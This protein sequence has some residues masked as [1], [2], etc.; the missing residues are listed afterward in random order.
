MERI[1]LLFEE[2]KGLESISKIYLDSKREIKALA[3]EIESLRRERDSI[4]TR[5][6]DDE[7]SRTENELEMVV[8]EIEC[9]RLLSNVCLSVNDLKRFFDEISDSPT[10]LEKSVEFMRNL[11]V[12]FTLGSQA[13][14]SLFDVTGEEEFYSVLKIDKD[15]EK[16][17]ELIRTRDFYKSALCEFRN[18]MK[19]ELRNTVPFDIQ[20]F[21]SRKHIF[22]VY[23]NDE[24]GAFQDDP[25]SEDVSRCSFEDLFANFPLATSCTALMLKENLSRAII[26]DNYSPIDI[27]ENN[28]KLANT[29]FYIKNVDEWVIDVVMRYVISISKKEK[30]SGEVVPLEDPVSGRLVSEDYFFIL[31]CLKFI[32]NSQSKRRNKAMDVFSRSMLKFFDLGKCAAVK[33]YFVMYS[34]LTHFVKRYKEFVYLEDLIRLREE[35]FH[36]ILDISTAIEIDLGLSVLM[37]K[38]KIKQLQFE[39]DEHVTEFISK[40]ARKFFRIQ[41]FERLYNGFISFVLNPRKCSVQ[42]KDILKELAQYLLDISY[43]IEPE[44][45]FSFTK[46]SNIHEML[47]SSVGQVIAM[48]S[49]SGTSLEKTELRTFVRIFF[50]SSPQRDR[51]LDDLM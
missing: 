44:C 28:R 37:L 38:A 7:I 45:I 21:T 10:C 46:V 34:S 32:E 51:F 9:S 31:R 24:G 17:L 26:Q 33:D 3:D 6:I 16:L 41:F 1:H 49:S 23:P 48:Y 30:V 20:I 39:F 12:E 42:E 14:S 25:F 50:N 47:G 11:V 13:V 19:L 18:M 4:D 8:K 5:P 35:A 22:M 27:A 43:G 15:I 2:L 40:Q 29:D 36:K